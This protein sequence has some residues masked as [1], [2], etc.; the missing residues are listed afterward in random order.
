M[1]DYLGGNQNMPLDNE[2]LAF[3]IRMRTNYFGA[4]YIGDPYDTNS[5][6]NDDTIGKKYEQ[7]GIYL[8]IFDTRRYPKQNQIDITRGIMTRVRVHPRCSDFSSCISNARYPTRS[9]NSQSTAE[10]R[11]PIHDKT[12]H[13]RS[14]LEYLCTY[15]EDRKV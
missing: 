4:T 13:Y 14:A 3:F 2:Q 12:S 11:L 10:I 7:R 15:I 8:N 5:T 9:D 6:V 1:A